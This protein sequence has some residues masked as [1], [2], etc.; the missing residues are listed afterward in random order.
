MESN[1]PVGALKYFRRD[2]VAILVS[3][4]RMFYVDNAARYSCAFVSI[5]LANKLRRETP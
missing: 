3:N 2:K 1:Y 4:R 5:T